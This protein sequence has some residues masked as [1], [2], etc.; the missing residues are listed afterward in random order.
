MHF[1]EHSTGTVGPPV[2][3]VNIKLV[4]WEEGNY[5]VTDK[6]RPRGEIL[7][8]GENV[9]AGYYN[10]PDKTSEEYF[11]DVTGRRW[12]RTGDIGLVE[13]NGAIKITDRKK[14]LVKLQYGEYVSLGKVESVLKTCALVENICIYGDSTKSFVVALVCPDKINLERLAA[15]LGK[16]NLNLANLYKVGI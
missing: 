1:E 4:N 8:G 16:T 2:Q 3:G 14:D 6:P 5:R 15:S 9:T 7:V 12:F 11:T 13:E 10:Q